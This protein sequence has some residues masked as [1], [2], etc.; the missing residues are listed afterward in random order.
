MYATCLFCQNRFER[1]Q[2]IESFPVG[3]RLAFDA[4]HGRLWVV[5]R[6]CE[7]WN[8]SAID[9]RWEAIEDC[10][11][12]FSNARR[13]VS[14]E[15]IGL[16]RLDSGLELVRIGDA[17][18]PEF[19]AW[20]YGDQFGRRRRKSIISGSALAVAVGAAVA[21]ALTLGAVAAGGYWTYW[22]AN[23]FARRR[24]KRHL[25]ARIPTSEGKTLTVLGEHLAQARLATV[26]GD[27]T[28]WKLTLQH[29][30]GTYTLQNDE[31]LLAVSL[32]MPT[33][34]GSGGTQSMVER[35]VKRLE[36]FDDPTRYL[37]SAAATSVQPGRVGR[38][39][40]GLPVDIRLAI[41]MAANEENER[42]LAQGQMFLLEL[43]WEEAEEIAAIADNLTVPADIEARIDELRRQATGRPVSN[44]AVFPAP[45]ES[46][47]LPDAESD[48][49]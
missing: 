25:I 48:N 20:R 2:T 34:N 15:N 29:L 42:F 43:A 49:S 35:A 22:A 23:D 10:E 44:A 27:S 41:E 18:R 37:L 11:R 17:L 47:A 39:L 1:N 31:A 32:I 45:P 33:I 5:C 38:V 24:K 21:G 46:T 8:L 26:V 4:A 36:N 19:A 9:E 7:R 28:G 3:D 13:R 12:L 16:A 30:Q 6:S 40:A 14:A